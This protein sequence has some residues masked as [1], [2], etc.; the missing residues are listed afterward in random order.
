MR[1]VKRCIRK[2][3]VTM[4]IYFSKKKCMVF[5][6]QICLCNIYKVT[7]IIFIFFACAKFIIKPLFSSSDIAS[8]VSMSHWSCIQQN[9]ICQSALNSGSQVIYSDSFIYSYSK[10]DLCQLKYNLLIQYLCL[11]IIIIQI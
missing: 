7:L 10:Q 9:T 2:T 8:N 1:S 11:V 4:R 6:H 3:P 5:T